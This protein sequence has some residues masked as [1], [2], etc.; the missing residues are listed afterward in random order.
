MVTSTEEEFLVKKILVSLILITCL[1]MISVP[2]T[3]AND[4]RGDHARLTGAPAMNTSQGKDIRSE[5]G[6]G[7][8]NTT[9]VR[10]TNPGEGQGE[11]RGNDTRNT[12]VDTDK[13]IKRNITAQGNN[14]QKDT[15]LAG[16]P[17]RNA[18][19]VRPGWTKNPNMVR[20]AVHSLL[21][22][23]NTTGGIGQQVS[24]IARDFNNS[25]SSSEQLENRIENRD[26]L[27][28]FLF[29]GDKDAAAQLA[30]LTA[31]NRASIQ[32]IQ[33]LMSTTTLDADTQTTIDEQLQVLLAEQDRLDALS[34][35]ARQEHGLFG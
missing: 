13:T 33:Q 14:N 4:D 3:A 17:Y 26:F 6:D 32:K 10:E 11:L 16:A 8:L 18:T 7:T 21:A 27:S 29:G 28:R 34:S 22:L 25:A 35:Q 2:V 23:G 12:G 20:D 31:Q 30:T 9:H 15:E 5:N 19:P 1:V 24:T